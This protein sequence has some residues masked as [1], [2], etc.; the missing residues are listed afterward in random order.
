M[1][2]KLD[3]YEQCLIDRDRQKRKAACTLPLKSR[4]GINKIIGREIFP[5]STA[6]TPF[7]FLFLSVV[8]PLQ[9]LVIPR[10]TTSSL[11]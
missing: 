8:L 1:C 4:V 5:S 2:A 10:R 6:Q 3:S 9:Q 7:Q 11:V